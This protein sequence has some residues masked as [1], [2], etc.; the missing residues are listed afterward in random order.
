MHLE[1]PVSIWSK[2]SSNFYP[3]EIWATELALSTQLFWTLPQLVYSLVNL[4]ILLH[5]R[6]WALSLFFFFLIHLQN[7]KKVCEITG[8]SEERTT[9]KASGVHGSDQ[10]GFF[11]HLL[12][13]STIYLAK[14]NPCLTTSAC[15]CWGRPGF[16]L[17]TTQSKAPI[18]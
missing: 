3:N 10:V 7:P 9:A 4:C 5:P 13:L 14:L 2:H 8:T 15:S 12:A 16:G 18:Y 6:P 17:F 11:Y 1:W